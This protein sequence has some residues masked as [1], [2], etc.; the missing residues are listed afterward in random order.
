MGRRRR[1]LQEN[2]LTVSGH[3]QAISLGLVVCLLFALGGCSTT[4]SLL[5]SSA[6]QVELVD[7]PF[8][9][10]RRY[11]CGPAALATVL[12]ASQVRVTPEEIEPLVYLPGRKG[13]LQIEML[14]AP[15]KY[16]RL[17]YRLEPDLAAI[18]SELRAG[19]PVLV[20][21]NYGL[22]LWPRWHYAVVIGHDAQKDQ[23]LLRSGLQPREAWSARNFMRA[24]DNG[25]RWGVVMLRPGELPTAPDKDRYLEAAAA[26]EKVAAPHEAWLAFNSAVNAWPNEPVAW[27]GRGTA[28]YRDMAFREAAADYSAALR[29]EPSHAGARNNLAMTLLKHGCPHAA[30]WQLDKIDVTLLDENLR[31]AVADTARQIDADKSRADAA[32]CIATP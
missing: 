24:W 8:F 4:G 32:A 28:K 12:A 29:L 18:V 25:D 7:T 16:G 2:S 3:R 27:I 21:H 22:P 26:F 6:G 19:R 17:S 10:Q 11:Q 5:E 14:A 9:P 1:H 23:L 15:R 20:L 13:S 31:D 30:R